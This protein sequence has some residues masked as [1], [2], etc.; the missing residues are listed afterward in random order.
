MTATHA[1]ALTIPDTVTTI[2][3]RIRSRNVRTVVD[4]IRNGIDLHQA[5]T[6]VGHGK[7]GAEKL[8]L[9]QEAGYASVRT[10]ERHMQVASSMAKTLDVNFLG[11]S[12]LLPE[13]ETRLS[14]GNLSLSAL[15][16]ITE[17]ESNVEA[18]NTL[19][20]RLGDGGTVTANDAKQII[21]K[22]ATE[23]RLTET[24]AKPL[25]RDLAREHNL[26]AAAV[27]ALTRMTPEEVNEVAASGAVYNPVA[28]VEVPVGEA[29]D[30]TW[31]TAKVVSKKEKLNRDKPASFDETGTLADLWEQLVST[32]VPGQ[33]YRFI[34]Y[35]RKT[36]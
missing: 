27:T 1:P 29:D 31:E 8:A 25:V 10:A 26:S 33:P 13:L 17:A 2:I 19:F 20:A 7:W 12:A 18:I 24:N 32:L 3:G 6:I 28:D 15:Y 22:Q 30:A 23:R 4:A 36:A 9:T 21:R 5:K 34:A 14:S 11:L 16:A 35:E